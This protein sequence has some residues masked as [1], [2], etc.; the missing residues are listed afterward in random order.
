MVWNKERAGGVEPRGKEQGKVFSLGGVI[1]W[2]VLL[3]CWVVAGIVGDV[4]A[5]G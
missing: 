5:A 3:W 2:L 1:C 4:I